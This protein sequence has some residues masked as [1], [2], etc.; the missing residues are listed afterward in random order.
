MISIK[1]HHFIDIITSFGTGQ[2]TFQSH[3]YGHNVHTVSQQILDDCNMILEMELDADDI[4][5]PCI[6]NINGVCDDNLQ[7]RS[8]SKHDFNT[9]LDARLFQQLGL[10]E[11]MEM[12]AGDFCRVLR[13]KFG[14]PS[15]IWTHLSSKEAKSRFEMMSK[16]IEKLLGRRFT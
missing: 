12:E 1:P 5:K 6:H 2:R 16:G 3:P 8:M 10:S 13:G 15:Q 7:D 11:D 9:A 4:C 14:E